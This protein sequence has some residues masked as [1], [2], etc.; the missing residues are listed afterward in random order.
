M[1]KSLGFARLHSI[2]FDH[3]LSHVATFL[4]VGVMQV[5]LAML[6]AGRVNMGVLLAD[7]VQAV[8]DCRQRS[9]LRGLCGDVLRQA[10]QRPG[11]PG[12]L[13]Q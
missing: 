2:F 11:G 12:G 6:E 13:L 10:S 4:K 7:P 8:R 9:H 1:R 3:T 5:V